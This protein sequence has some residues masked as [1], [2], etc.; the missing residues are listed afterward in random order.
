EVVFEDVSF[1]YATGGEELHSVSLR[2]PRG[3][4]TALV[5]ASGASQSPPV[6]LVAAFHAPGAG[7]VL[8]DGV[9][10]ST[11]T[12]GSYRSQLGVVLQDTF[13]FD[14]TVREHRGDASCLAAT[15]RKRVSSPRPQAGDDEVQAACR[16]ARVDEFV[17][18]FEQGYE[19]V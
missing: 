17:E 18:R 12:L 4:V 13:L 16:V 3:G 6:G 15:V 11:V 1:S 5:G 9:D 8:V 2:A 14:G 19:T 7:R 10:L